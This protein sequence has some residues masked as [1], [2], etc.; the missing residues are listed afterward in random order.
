VAPRQL[1]KGKIKEINL[2]LTSWESSGGSYRRKCNIA[3]TRFACLNTKEMI[4]EVTVFSQ[5]TM[6]FYKQ[7]LSRNGEMPI[8]EKR[9]WCA[10]CAAHVWWL[11]VFIVLMIDG[12]SGAGNKRPRNWIVVR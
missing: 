12:E 8:R 10:R 1:N 3:H 7:P 11:R 2:K 4:I 6:Q 9:E 5:N